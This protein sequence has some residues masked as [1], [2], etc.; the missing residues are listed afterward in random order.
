MSSIRML[1]SRLRKGR[2]HARSLL[3]GFAISTVPSCSARMSNE[4]GL[5]RLE[6]R[7]RDDARSDDPF[8]DEEAVEMGLNNH[9]RVELFSELSE[10]HRTKLYSCGRALQVSARTAFSQALSLLFWAS[11]KKS[12]FGNSVWVFVEE[13]PKRT[14][15]STRTAPMPTPYKLGLSA[16]Q[17]ERYG[18]YNGVD[19][20]HHS[21]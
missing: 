15:A 21:A 17:V 19:G 4:H 1:M 13:D 6:G 18:H 20:E 7:G 5:C 11:A 9:F 3:L 12:T 16:E 2:S 8:D 10:D 14:S